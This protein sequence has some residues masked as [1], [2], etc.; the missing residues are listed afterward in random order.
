MA[1]RTPVTTPLRALAAALVLVAGLASC[2]QPTPPPAVTPV[3]PTPVPTPTPPPIAS[4]TGVSDPRGLAFDPDGMLWLTGGASGSESPAGRILKLDASGTVV[5][6]RD[7][8][9]ALGACAVAG[10]Y[11]WTVSASPSATLWRITRS[12][13]ATASFDLT[14]PKAVSPQAVIADAQG[15]VWVADASND[16]VSVFQDGVKLQDITLPH[17]TDSFGPTGLVV[18]S[19]SVWVAARGDRRLYQVKSSDLSV[20]G[21]VDLQKPATGVLGVDKNGLVWAGH[22]FH[23]G[24][25]SVSKFANAGT[26]PRPYDL[27]QESPAALVGDQRGYVWAAL[28]DKHQVVRVTPSD[29]RMW[30][31]ASDAIVRPQAIA[32]DAQGN[33]WVASPEVLARIPAAP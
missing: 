29:G 26:E 9:L 25:L 21:Q 2:A 16:R 11:L 3:T 27:G 13:L 10:D 31:Y 7:L 22:E 24:T 4:F 15:R 17:A 28:R 12:D 14:G 19:E 5:D 1:V 30:A 23:Q 33:A 32:V 20:V 8:G 18:A 6:K